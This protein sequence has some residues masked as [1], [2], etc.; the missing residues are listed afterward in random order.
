[1]SDGTG[2]APYAAD[3]ARAA[4]RLIPEPP[5]R[6][7]NEFQRDRD[8]IVHSTAFRRLRQL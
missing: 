1:M 8:R 6:T 3:P 7:R 2:R 4:A 5:S